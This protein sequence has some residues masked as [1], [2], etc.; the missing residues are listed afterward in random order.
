M[1]Y[2]FKNI[3]NKFLK[4]NFNIWMLIEVELKLLRRYINLLTVF[5]KK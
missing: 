2:D 4:L 3:E 1:E 5:K